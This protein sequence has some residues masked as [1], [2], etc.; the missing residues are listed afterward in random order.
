V[1]R[2]WKDLDADGGVCLWGGSWRDDGVRM[3]VGVGGRAIG[4]LD[5]SGEGGEEGRGAVPEK[6][7]N[8]SSIFRPIL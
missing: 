1:E 2:C 6:S 7:R 5:A 8:L 3:S 4:A